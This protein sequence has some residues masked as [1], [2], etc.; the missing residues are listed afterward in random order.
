MTGGLEG[1]TEESL[2]ARGAIGLDEAV[3]ASARQ[4]RRVWACIVGEWEARINDYQTTQLKQ[5]AITTNHFFMSNVTQGLLYALFLTSLF[6]FVFRGSA[7]RSHQ[8]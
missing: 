2:E 8:P 7:R 1:G 6:A 4:H 5:R 3:A